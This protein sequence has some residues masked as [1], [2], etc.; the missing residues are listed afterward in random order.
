MQSQSFHWFKPDKYTHNLKVCETHHH[1]EAEGFSWQSG[2]SRRPRLPSGALRSLR[3]SLSRDPWITLRDQQ[4]A[5]SVLKLRNKSQTCLLMLLTHNLKKSQRQSSFSNLKHYDDPNEITFGPMIP[6]K[7]GS[8]CQKKHKMCSVNGK[9][10][11]KSIFNSFHISYKNIL[12]FALFLHLSLVHRL[13]HSHPKAT[14][15][16]T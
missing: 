10:M 16:T 6:G 1:V 4:R 8:P 14:E 9:W 15:I 13:V 2:G 7:P 11:E 5:T 12:L 3:P